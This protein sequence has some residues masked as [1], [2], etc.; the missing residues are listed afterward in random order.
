MLAFLIIPLVLGAGAGS[1]PAKKKKAEPLPP[2]AEAKATPA[3]EKVAST[4][5][6]PKPPPPA[7]LTAPG[8]PAAKLVRGE[9]FV[10]PS[11]AQL[12]EEWADA[13]AD[14]ELA[15]TADRRAWLPALALGA[16]TPL[17]A[18]VAVEVDGAATR[19]AARI[20][21]G[22]TAGWVGHASSR[23]S[24]D[25]ELWGAEAGVLGRSAQIRAP[26]HS[27]TNEV[28]VLPSVEVRMNRNGTQMFAAAWNDP[29][30]PYSEKGWLRVGA[31]RELGKLAWELGLGVD[32]LM[33]EDGSGPV[34]D[35]RIHR[36][37]GRGTWL[38]LACR[39]A[40]EPMAAAVIQKRY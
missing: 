29:L 15:T 37:V 13:M 26:G 24:Y 25:R 19:F 36:S 27:R 28:S 1:A 14:G 22:E 32:N 23:V 3:P 9:V 11:Y 20:P 34:I 16:R 2:P 8:L 5:P 6:V 33:E 21:G 39:A 40:D 35:V 31:R 4:A 7:K 12:G 30:L 38:G 17:F 10:A 18:G